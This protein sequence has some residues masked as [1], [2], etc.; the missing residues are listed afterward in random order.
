MLVPWFVDTPSGSVRAFERHALNLEGRNFRAHFQR[1]KL[2]ILKR[3]VC[4]FDEPWCQWGKQHTYPL[5]AITWGNRVTS[6]Y[7]L[8]ET[9]GGKAALANIPGLK[10]RLLAPP[11]VVPD[12]IIKWL[13]DHHNSLDAG[14]ATTLSDAL[15]TYAELEA[16][17]HAHCDKNGI[18]SR[19]VPD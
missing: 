2:S 3:G 11:P 4:Q 10:V 8:L 15:G 13:R 17:W 12:S 14:M 1:L 18:T 9:E 5:G 7:E 19:G 16:K 6:I